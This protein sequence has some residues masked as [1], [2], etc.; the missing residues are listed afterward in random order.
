ML[1]QAKPYL[2]IR[3]NR[4]PDFLRLLLNIVGFYNILTKILFYISDQMK[5]I[6]M[7]KNTL[8]I[9]AVTLITITACKKDV[10]ITL[11]NYLT[12]NG[13]TY[14]LTET[15]D[16]TAGHYYLTGV[17]SGGNYNLDIDFGAKPL[18]MYIGVGQEPATLSFTDS[19]NNK[20]AQP[21]IKISDN[22]G[23][24]W[25]AS[26]GV[27]ILTEAEDGSSTK[28]T[29]SNVTFIALSGNAVGTTAT[30]TASGSLY[31]AI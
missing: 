26:N 24:T 15:T 18:L 17:S 14:N 4:Y 7:L 10:P 1:K 29:F 19:L 16:T 22:K 31:S 11:P 21:V 2:A 23:N 9:F 5:Q 28:V 13:T 3:Q 20:K 25:V 6:F 30:L 12:V 27:A 8:F